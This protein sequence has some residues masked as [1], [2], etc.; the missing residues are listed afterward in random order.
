MRS[1]PFFSITEPVA[2]VARELLEETD[3]YHK[4]HSARLARTAEIIYNEIGQVGRVLE[5]GTSGFIPLVFKRLLPETEVHVTHFDQSNKIT[6]DINVTLGKNT[7]AVKAFNID[8]EKD[9]IPVSN[10]RYDAVICCEVLEHM[11]IDPMFMLAEVNRVLKPGGILLL[12]TP[13]IT[14][15]RALYK[16]LN[17]YEPHFFMQYHRN[18][19]Y[20]RHNYEYSAPTLVEVLKAAGFSGKVWSEDLFDDPISSIVEQLRS[21]GFKLEQPGD[22]LIALATKV[23]DVTE[24]HPT[25]IYV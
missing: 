18:R 3:G 15:S 7:V 22:N 10:E 16:I 21:Y 14:S 23:S 19:E 17:G 12:T 6:Q 9:S 4:V 5:F 11:E 24:R 8:L 2:S 13:N 20:H 25:Q 1:H